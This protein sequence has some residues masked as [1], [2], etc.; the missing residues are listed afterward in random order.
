MDGTGRR[1]QSP[2]SAG[3]LGC[4]RLPPLVHIVRARPAANPTRKRTP[5]N[6]SCTA[7]DMAPRTG[8][9]PLHILYSVGRV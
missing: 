1:G 7:R 3:S 2:Y 5:V 4:P 8:R 9:R 6:T